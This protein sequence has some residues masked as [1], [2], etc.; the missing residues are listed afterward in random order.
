MPTLST[1]SPTERMASGDSARRR[2]SLSVRHVLQ[3]LTPPPPPAPVGAK[4]AARLFPW[5]WGTVMLV[6]L[7]FSL[8]GKLGNVCFAFICL[9]V[10]FPANFLFLG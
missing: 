8:T 6:S 3:L 7:S 4:R 1:L 10:H 9:H 5:L 2:D